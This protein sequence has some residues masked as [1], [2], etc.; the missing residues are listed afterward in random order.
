MGNL[1][2][3]TR[4]GVKGLGGRYRDHFLK[5]LQGVCE[6]P[7]QYPIEHPPDIRHVRLR[8]FPLMLIYRE[9]EGGSSRYLRWPITLGL[10]GRSASDK[11]SALLGE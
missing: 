9:R 10:P 6:R 4:L 1:S 11:E 5:I 2:P 7:A 3:S 8:P